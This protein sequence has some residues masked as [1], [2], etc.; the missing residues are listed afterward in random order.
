VTV[1]RR[2]VKADG[3]ARIGDDPFIVVSRA[4]WKMRR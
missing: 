3:F 2:N 1:A 4:W